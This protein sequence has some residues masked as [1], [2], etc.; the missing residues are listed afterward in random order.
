M[1]TIS[2]LMFVHTRQCVAF[3]CQWR[4]PSFQS[5]PFLIPSIFLKIA[6]IMTIQYEKA[7]HDFPLQ[8]HPSLRIQCIHVIQANRSRWS[9]GIIDRL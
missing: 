2:N 8:T 7:V 4:Q 6:Y 3:S 5:M 9:C 1:G